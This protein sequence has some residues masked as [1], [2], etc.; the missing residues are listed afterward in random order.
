MSQ[1]VIGIFDQEDEARKALEQ[2]E[3]NG[4]LSSQV[5]LSTS[6]RRVLTDDE[7]T[8]DDFG[9]KVSRFFRSLFGNE[10]SDK[11]TNVARNRP[12]VTVIAQSDEEATRASEILDNCGA[13]DVDEHAKAY[14]RS[15]ALDD[16]RT[17]ESDGRYDGSS[18]TGSY[19]STDSPERNINA[20]ITT[21]SNVFD[22]EDEDTKD[23][24]KRSIPVV[25][26][27][28]HVGKR[29][30]EN[31]GVRLRS[32]IVERPVEET[33]R[34]RE[35]RVWVDRTEADRPATDRDFSTFKEGEI[36][37]K[38]RAEVPVVNKEAR[39]VEEL[40]V[41]RDVTEREET[42]RDT[43]RS[44]EVD[45]DETAADNQTTNKRSRT[46]TDEDLV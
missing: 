3:S 16:D 10:E 35:E 28:L 25:R 40:R 33:V 18:T 42:I 11:Y 8:D 27:E 21:D 37:I 24:T 32:R 46:E 14:E 13:I 19:A 22:L 4:F 20:D 2:L 5:D 39:V 44:T 26:E 43:V 6:S 36:R 41:N 45:V 38:Q 29:Q 34:L 30:V 9:D 1:T 12:I 17:Y 23:I 31:G 15:N 7:R